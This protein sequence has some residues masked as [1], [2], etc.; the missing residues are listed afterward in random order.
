MTKQKKYKGV[1]KIAKTY[2]NKREKYIFYDTNKE[3]YKICPICGKSFTKK[4]I[5]VY[6]KAFEKRIY[7]SQECMAKDRIGN[8]YIFKIGHTIN[9]GREPWNKNLKGWTKSYSV[10][11]I[12]TIKRKKKGTGKPKGFQKGN[13]TK[14]QYKEGHK[15]MIG[16]NNPN[17]QDGKSFEAYSRDFNYKLK[18]RIRDRSGNICSICGKDKDT[19]GRELDVHHIDY[20]KKNNNP[21]NLIALCHDCHLLTNGNR[22]HWKDYFQTMYNIALNLEEVVSP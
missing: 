1:G 6:G 21:N 3:L 16:V 9:V 11:T 10:Y 17:W 4:D 8:D 13:K 15:G 5:S 2:F 14:S 19:N 22:N 12:K 7:C 20:N 18:K